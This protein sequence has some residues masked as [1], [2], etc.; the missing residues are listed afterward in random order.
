VTAVDFGEAPQLSSVKSRASV[1][2]MDDD[3]FIAD[4]ETSVCLVVGSDHESEGEA[5]EVEKKKSEETLRDMVLT[6]NEYF[7]RTSREGENWWE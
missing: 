7:N 4:H 3:W 6:A 2:V 5:T 1:P